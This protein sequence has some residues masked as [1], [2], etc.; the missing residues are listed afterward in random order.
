[1]SESITKYFWEHFHWLGTGDL[2]TKVPPYPFYT[3]GPPKVEIKIKNID[4]KLNKSL[5]QSIGQS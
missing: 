4:N 3:K 2:G 5:D 1:M